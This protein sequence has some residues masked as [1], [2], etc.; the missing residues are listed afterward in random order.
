MSS[1]DLLKNSICFENL[2]DIYYH[3]VRPKAVAGLDKVDKYKFDKIAEN[4]FQIIERKVLNGKYKFTRY[5]KVFISKGEGKNPRVINI[6]TIRDKIVLTILNNCFNKIYNNSNCSKLPH[7]IIN[8]MKDTIDSQ[9][10]NYFIKYDIKSFYA[11]IKHSILMR[12]IR[13]KVRNASFLNVIYNAI[14]NDGI[15]FPIK[16]LNKKTVRKEGIPEGLSISNSLANIYLISLDEKMMNLPN[17]KYNRYVDDIMIICNYEEKEEIDLLVRK[18][19]CKKLKL[20]LN[21]KCDEGFINENDFEYLGYRFEKE[22]LSV[23]KSSRYKLENSI[24]ILLAKYRLSEI[25]NEELLQWKLNL[26]ISGCIYKDKKYGWMFFYSQ[27]NDMKILSQI[28]WL[29]LKLLKRYKINIKPKKFKRTYYEIKNNLHNT[30]YIINFDNYSFEQKKDVLK[31][32][33]K[34]NIE[35]L[36]P[37]QINDL[38]ESIIFKDIA[39]LEEDIQHF[40]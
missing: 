1:F 7:L 6:P 21:Q 11:S 23:R 36:K 22:I 16:K 37:A 15:E 14:T 20:E 2:K 13:Y 5:K 30:K 18:E 17:I 39:L 32:I 24:E 33:Y 28:D 25:Q 29:V 8:D 35:G 27:I 31:R 19:V 3:K 26:K 40:S 4:E 38:F 34:R 9:K 12:K 10:Y